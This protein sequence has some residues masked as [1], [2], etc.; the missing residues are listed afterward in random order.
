MQKVV[1]TGATSSIGIAIIEKCIENN[2]EV[3]AI[4]NRGSSNI[5]KIR[6]HSLVTI[7]EASLDE[8]SPERFGNDNSLELAEANNEVCS[9]D[10]LKEK[11]KGAAF[12]HLAWAST[13]GDAARNLL[14]PQAMN[15][16]YSLDA[17]DLAESLGCSVFVGAGSQAEYGRKNENLTEETKENPET[18]YGMAKLCAGQMTRL[19]C[20]Q[21]GIRHIWPRILS[22]YGPNCPDRTVVNYSLIELIND[23]SP[24]LTGCQQIWDFIYIDDVAKALLLLA[25]KG[26]DGQ[27]YVIGS[28]ISKELKEYLI[29]MRQLL[30]EYKGKAVKE[31]DLGANPYGP[32]TV[33]HLSC[34]ID[35]LRK[36]T[37]YE[38]D[39]SFEEGMKKTIEWMSSRCDIIVSK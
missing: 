12:I 33:M 9:G 11:Y 39:Y 15:I 25:D 2:I 3:L 17:V 36:D 30:I 32:N 14:V 7:V 38:P 35:K 19:A 23:N 1:L 6:K 34:S 4:A 27:I 13:G 28:G 20:Q 24:K 16:K 26:V 37:G 22:A 10:L 5:K 29:E 31:L 18:A 21:K 8:L